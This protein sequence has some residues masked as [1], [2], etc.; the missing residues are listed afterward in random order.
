MIAEI[1]DLRPGIYAYTQIEKSG[2]IQVFAPRITLNH[3]V[4]FLG[5]VLASSVFLLMTRYGVPE[6][7]AFGSAILSVLVV[8]I[9]WTAVNLGDEDED[10]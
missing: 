4:A 6:K 1:T 10:E 2:G 8:S 7:I 3:A 5:V 9:F